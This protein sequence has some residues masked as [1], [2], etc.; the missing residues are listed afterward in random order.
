MGRPEPDRAC[1][2][3]GTRFI[4]A[5]ALFARAERAADGLAAGP[6]PELTEQEHREVEKTL[7]FAH[8][9]DRQSRPWG[10]TE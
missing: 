3:S 5:D 6:A 10:H 2:W 8:G 1:A 9:R 4:E 7:T